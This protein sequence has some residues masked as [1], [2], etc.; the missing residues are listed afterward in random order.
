MQK[1]LSS[2]W[3]G[4]TLSHVISARTFNAHVIIVSSQVALT[5]TLHYMFSTL[6]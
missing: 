5:I 6:E 4:G 3:S 1:M 2:T